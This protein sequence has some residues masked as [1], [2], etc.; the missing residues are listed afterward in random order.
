MANQGEDKR[1]KPEPDIE[2]IVVDQELCLGCASC[3]AMAP[4]TFALNNEGK[5]SVINPKAA[6]DK[7]LKQIARFCPVKAILLFNKEGKRI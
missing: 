5:S 4:A 7:T 3:V 1:K 2:K 6:D